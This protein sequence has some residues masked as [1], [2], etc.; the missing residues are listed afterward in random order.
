[1]GAIHISEQAWQ[2]SRY[3]AVHGALQ[4]LLDSDARLLPPGTEGV[5]GRAQYHF[6]RIGNQAAAA[7]L[8]SISIA[9]FRLRWAHW[10]RREADLRDVGQELGALAEQWFL[11]APMLPGE[12]PD[13]AA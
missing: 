3:G 5:I 9:L 2:G 4:R 13:H 12:S 8:E 10:T 6:A 7:R 11:A 1:M